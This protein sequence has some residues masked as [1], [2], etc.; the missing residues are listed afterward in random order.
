MPCRDGYSYFGGACGLQSWEG[1]GE[2]R[3]R[4]SLCGRET[5]GER[6]S[7]NPTEGWGKCTWGQNAV[8][9][10]IK[11]LVKQGR[12]KEGRGGSAWI[13]FLVPCVVTRTHLL[14]DQEDKSVGP[15]C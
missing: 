11:E 6:E 2:G 13:L 9:A 14:V 4:G 1:R 8:Q 7:G 5:R 10:E 3:R 12:R 15:D